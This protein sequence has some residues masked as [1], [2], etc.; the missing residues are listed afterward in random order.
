MTRD[1]PE[2]LSALVYIIGGVILLAAVGFGVDL[3]LASGAA[4]DIDGPLSHLTQ[5]NFT[6]LGAVIGGVLGGFVGLGL[7]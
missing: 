1:S 5:Y 6:L 7:V 2:R 3:A 4:L